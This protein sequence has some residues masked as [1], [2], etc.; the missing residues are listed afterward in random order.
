MSVHLGASSPAIRHSQLIKRDSLF[1]LQRVTSVGGAR[2][3]VKFPVSD[4]TGPEHAL[5]EHEFAVFQALASERVL[6]PVRFDASGSLVAHYEDCDGLPL[7]V[8]ST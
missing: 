8:V 1:Q 2:F 4:S 5:L 7:D 6:A 3:L